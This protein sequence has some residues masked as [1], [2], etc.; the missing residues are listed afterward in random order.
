MGNDPEKKPSFRFVM[1]RLRLQV[2]VASC[3][4]V[5]HLGGSKGWCQFLRDA[6]KSPLSWWPLGTTW[7]TWFWSWGCFYLGKAGN[8]ESWGCLVDV[9]FLFLICRALRIKHFQCMEYMVRRISWV[10]SIKFRVDIAM[11][12]LHVEC[13]GRTLP[14]FISYC[15][16]QN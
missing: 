7:C 3:P 15:D 2:C 16:H 8:T 1:E 11:F 14:G 13:R 12:W 10:F 9:F 4:C 6:L 5:V